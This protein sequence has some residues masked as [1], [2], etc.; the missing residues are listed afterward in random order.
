MVLR[1]LESM[2]PP[3]TNRAF[4]HGVIECSWAITL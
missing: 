1:A 2:D 3:S 4:D